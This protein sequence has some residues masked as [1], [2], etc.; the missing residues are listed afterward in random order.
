MSR[1][2]SP[3][4]DSWLA[5]CDP[6]VKVA[7]L[8]AGSIATLFLFEPLP[9]L[10]LHL[11]ALAGVRGTTGLRWRTLLLAQLPFV[12][13]GLGLVVVNA[14]ARPG[15]PLLA[16]APV[17]VSV[18]GVVIGLA[19]ALRSL[20]IGTMTVGF[21]ASTSPRALMT[22]LVQHAG[23]SPRYA[24]ALLAGHRMLAAMPRTWS[25]IRTA[26]AV[27]APLG[28]DGRPR[29][30]ARGLTRCAFAL[31]VSSIR[32]SER[33]ALALEVRGL[34]A[35]PRTVWRPASVGARDA[36]LAAAALAALGVVAMLDIL[37]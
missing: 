2:V 3:A 32:S 16:D 4:G 22:S 10:L 13:F 26:H 6:T 5:G 18:D 21:L 25:A 35:G 20:V 1:A 19:L 15:A 30:G 14:L 31:L 33:I 24:F 23:V 17:R 36:I 28:A 9:L 8:L 12:L 11:L 29:L 27:R 34:G 37:G 7:V